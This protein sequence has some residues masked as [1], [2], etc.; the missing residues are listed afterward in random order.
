MQRPIHLLSCA[1]EERTWPNDQ[2]LES[3]NQLSIQCETVTSQMTE[4]LTKIRS[5]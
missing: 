4:F 2:V 5:S 1:E 3:A